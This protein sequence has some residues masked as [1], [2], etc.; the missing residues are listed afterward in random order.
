[1]HNR[2]LASSNCDMPPTDAGFP[3]L[4][5]IPSSLA[6]AAAMEV[7][8]SRWRPSLLEKSQMGLLLQQLLLRNRPM[9]VPRT[10]SNPVAKFHDDQQTWSTMSNHERTIQIP[11]KCI[12]TDD[13]NRHAHEVLTVTSSSDTQGRPHIPPGSKTSVESH[14]GC[15]R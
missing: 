10:Q 11:K 7:P 5:V 1:M 3:T 2:S 8:L 15:G 13:T 4:P 12:I 9:C 6:G 14:K